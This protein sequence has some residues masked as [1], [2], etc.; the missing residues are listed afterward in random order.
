VSLSPGL[1]P[2]LPANE[3]KTTDEKRTGCRNQR[4]ELGKAVQWVRELAAKHRPLVAVP[5]TDQLVEAFEKDLLEVRFLDS[6]DVGVRMP[7]SVATGGKPDAYCLL[8]W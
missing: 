7:V 2:F 6:L 1:I 3:L 4:S 5:I 8:V